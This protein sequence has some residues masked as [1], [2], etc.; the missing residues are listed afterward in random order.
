MNECLFCKIIKGDTPSNTIYEDEIVKVFLDIHPDSVGHTLIIPKEHYVDLEDI[1]EEVISHI[2]SVSKIIKKRIQE[3]LKPDGMTL[4]Q[5]NGFVQE[6]KHFHL[7]LIPRY[8]GNNKKL[9]VS[10]VYDILRED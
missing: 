3:K 2:M 8:R 7:H 6:V 9:S 4:I 1:P 10:E 5:N